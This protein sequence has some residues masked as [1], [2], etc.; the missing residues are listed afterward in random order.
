[1]RGSL[2]GVLGVTPCTARLLLMNSTSVFA[3]YGTVFATLTV[4]EPNCVCT[5]CPAELL[6]LLGGSGL[7]APLQLYT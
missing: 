7:H 3:W 5:L 6:I 1:M 4:P 2:L